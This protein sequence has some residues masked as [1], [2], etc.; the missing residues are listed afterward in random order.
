MRNR[1]GR[2]SRVIV[3]GLTALVC[4]GSSLA[5]AQNRVIKVGVLTDQPGLYQELGSE[6]STLAAEMAAED[7][8]LRAKG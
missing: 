8:G 4:S 1:L 6:G 5:P 7:S 3:A 2:S